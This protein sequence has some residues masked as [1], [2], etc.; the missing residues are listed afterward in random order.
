MDPSLIRMTRETFNL[1]LSIPDTLKKCQNE[2]WDYLQYIIYRNPMSLNFFTFQE[3]TQR[4]YWL[5]ELDQEVG[6]F[7]SFSEAKTARAL[8]LAESEFNLYQ[9]WLNNFQENIYENQS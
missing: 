6:P 4:W 3:N 5:T 2:A 8:V 1:G 9:E 7:S